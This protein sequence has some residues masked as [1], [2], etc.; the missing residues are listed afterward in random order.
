VV[1]VVAATA[2]VYPYRTALGQSIESLTAG[3]RL[4]A[5]LFREPYTRDAL[6]ALAAASGTTVA[7]EVMVRADRIDADM[8]L[9]QGRVAT[10]D[11]FYERGTAQR[12][13]PAAIQPAVP[14][15]QFELTSVA[16]TK[17]LANVERAAR[18]SGLPV[19]SAF[20]IVQRSVDENIESE[21]F[22][23]RVGP[24]EMRIHLSGEDGNASF[25]TDADGT[26]FARVS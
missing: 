6:Q 17:I 26:G 7:S 13:G 12:R 20:A 25:M 11:W 16:W 15:E 19:A 21:S 1:F 5:N 23:D 14:G 9:V 4:H 24:V 2:V 22:G 10:D 18:E 8:P 3:Q